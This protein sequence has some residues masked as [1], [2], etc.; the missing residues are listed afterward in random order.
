M[1]L[2]IYN[3]TSHLLP[4]LL[5]VDLYIKYHKDVYNKNRHQPR[6]LPSLVC[7]LE[8]FLLLIVSKYKDGFLLDS[9]SVL[10]SF[11]LSVNFLMYRFLYKIFQKALASLRW[12]G[13]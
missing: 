11:K 6:L 9:A 2:T 8:S 13:K 3:D 5:L 1:D 7:M 10:K 12:V 4:C